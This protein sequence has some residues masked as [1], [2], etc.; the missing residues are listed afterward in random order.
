MPK[1]PINPRIIIAKPTGTRFVESKFGRKEGTTNSGGGVNV[2][3][4]VGVE[5]LMK[6]AERVGS[7]G[8]RVGV[9]VLGA[10]TR[11]KRPVLI[12]VT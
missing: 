3:N 12:M 4:R 6:A 9:R 7:I 11:G 10:G 5:G 1:A 8:A 2:G